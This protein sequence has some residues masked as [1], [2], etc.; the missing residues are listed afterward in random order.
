MPPSTGNLTFAR[1]AFMPNRLGY[2]GGP[3]S[4]TLLDYCAAGVGDGGLDTLLRRFQAAYPYLQFIARSSGIADPF[5]P[6]VVE[7]YWVGNALLDHI[8]M[9]DY[10][11]FID[12]QFGPRIPYKARKYVVANVPNGARP[13]HS[14]HVLEVSM[15]T[16]ALAESLPALDACRISWGKVL[17][18]DG[19]LVEVRYRPLAWAEGR[20]TLGLEQTREASRGVEGAR[21]LAGLQPG[22]FVSMHW[23]WV[24][25]E[26]SPR[27]AHNLERMTLHH[28]GLANRTL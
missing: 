22:A 13:H 8:E 19:D 27:Q 24:C 11:D 1:Y 14:F 26:L 7:A 12:A 6:R 5:D 23:G 15:K 17:R 21:H 4:D 2:C 28:I 25:D 18:T 3:G 20:I 9:R 10:Y 16:G